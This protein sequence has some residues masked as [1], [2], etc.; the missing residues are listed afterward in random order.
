MV[1]LGAHGIAL[2]EAAGDRPPDRASILVTADPSVL[3][4]G[5]RGFMSLP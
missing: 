3:A 5:Y 2:V 1:M 4:G